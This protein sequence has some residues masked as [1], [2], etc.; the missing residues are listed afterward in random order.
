[1][2][3]LCP[4]SLYFIRLECTCIKLKSFSCSVCLQLLYSRD[5]N[6]HMYKESDSL[7]A[8]LNMVESPSFL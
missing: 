2:S 7:K 5:L 1:M 3:T 4:F 6:Y 8:P